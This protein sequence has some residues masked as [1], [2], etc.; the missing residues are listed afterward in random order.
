MWEW[1]LARVAAQLR[2]AGLD[3]RAADPRCA[4]GAVR[5]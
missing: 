4:G 5:R 3:Q 2:H 1:L